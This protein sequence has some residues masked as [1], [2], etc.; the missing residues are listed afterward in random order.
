M[1]MHLV[2]LE[3]LILADGYP[4]FSLDLINLI[5]RLNGKSPNLHKFEVFLY[6]SVVIILI[7]GFDDS[8]TRNL[9]HLFFDSP[10]EREVKTLGRI[11]Y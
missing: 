2:P 7:I 9:S 8:R 3:M 10:D 4:L 6:P 11:I 1:L 5:V